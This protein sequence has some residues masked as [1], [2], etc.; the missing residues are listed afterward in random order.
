M[1]KLRTIRIGMACLCL[2]PLSG[3]AQDFR[4]TISGQVT[5]SSGAAIP[6]AKVTV[7]QKSTAQVS[8]V[9]ANQE[10]FYTVPYLTPTVYNVEVSA[11]GFKSEQVQ[12][13]TLLVAQKLELPFKLAVGGVSEVIQVNASAE[14]I[15]TSDASGGLNFDSLQAS[16]YALN[17]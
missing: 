13:V 6:S 10:G 11:A 5:D 15:Q 9:Q 4:A 16:E 3:F 17:G 7:T 2:L 8:V 14:S 12:D 1:W